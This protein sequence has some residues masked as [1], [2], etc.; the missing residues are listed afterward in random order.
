MDA[1]FTMPLLFHHSQYVFGDPLLTPTQLADLSHQQSS[2]CYKIQ[3]LSKYIIAKHYILA[4]L[5]V[6]KLQSFVRSDFLSVKSI[7]TSCFY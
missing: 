6:L 4:K 2:I 7:M 5:K 1:L 3:I